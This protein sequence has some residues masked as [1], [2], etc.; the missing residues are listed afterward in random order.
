M[1]QAESRQPLT[2]KVR[3]RSQANRGQFRGCQSDSG[4]GFSLSTSV[5]PLSVTLHEPSTFISKH[6][7]L[8]PE[9]QRTDA[10]EPSKKQCSFGNR[11]TLDRKVLSLCSLQRDKSSE[12]IKRRRVY[13]LRPP[14]TLQSVSEIRN[15]TAIRNLKCLL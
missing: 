11:G 6:M 13:K 1:V 5:F 3:A 12:I 8:L 7:L 9:G 4:T 15:I 14:H 10:S 2:A